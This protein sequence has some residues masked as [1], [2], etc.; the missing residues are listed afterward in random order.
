L[1]QVVEDDMLQDLC[2][3]S[4]LKA[5]R[6]S[7]LLLI[8]LL[9]LSACGATP[10]EQ[11]TPPLAATTAPAEQPTSPPTPAAEPPTSVVEQP[12]A[13]PAPAAL[14]PAPPTTGP[15]APPTPTLEPLVS[16]TI[17]E[18]GDFDGSIP[19]NTTANDPAVG[20]ND[21]DGIADVTFQFFESDGKEIFSR[22]EKNARY[23]S[24]GGGD[25]GGDC[26][27]WVFADHNNQWPN[28]KPARSGPHKL[29]VTVRGVRGG[30]TQNQRNLWLN[31]N[32]QTTIEINTFLTTESSGDQLSFQA[33][34][35]D[36]SV[37]VEDGAGIVRVTFQFYNRQGQEV[38]ERIENTARY[39]A[40]SGGENGQPCNIWRFSEHGG[41]WPSDSPVENGA[42]YRLLVTA[43]GQSGQRATQRLEF[44]IQL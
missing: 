9:A 8:G 12:S 26:D 15:P 17:P 7:I 25:N 1:E 24:F 19:Y 21:G 6:H 29:L 11:P 30:T 35:H 27:Q 5:L 41:Q 16:N 10:V 34:A 39:C 31:L 14:T 33:E 38:Y 43:E 42:T 18:D 37:G 36:T 23:C 3:F 4:P 20:P 13:T 32:E 2:L 44:T 40:F 28:G 22:V